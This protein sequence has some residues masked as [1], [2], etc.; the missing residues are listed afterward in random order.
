MITLIFRNLTFDGSCGRAENCTM[1]Y[2]HG[3]DFITKENKKKIS[4]NYHKELSSF[5]NMFT[6]AFTNNFFLFFYQTNFNAWPSTF[7]YKNGTLIDLMQVGYHNLIS[8]ILKI[9]L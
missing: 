5:Q 6:A 4:K 1:R 7:P 9:Y 8:I 3:N 2:F